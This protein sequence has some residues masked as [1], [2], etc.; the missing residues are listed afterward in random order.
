MQSFSIQQRYP[1]RFNDRQRPPVSGEYA[2]TQPSHLHVASSASSKHHGIKM[3][4]CPIIGPNCS[5]E[6]KYC[7]SKDQIAS[8]WGKN[9]ECNGAKEDPQQY[10]RACHRS[11]RHSQVQLGLS[12]LPV[13]C[14]RITVDGTV[15]CRAVGKVG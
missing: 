5:G 12:T 14:S 4:T 2:W 3:G 1:I 6:D 9:I 13:G 11:I 8:G 15:L 10:W 7:A